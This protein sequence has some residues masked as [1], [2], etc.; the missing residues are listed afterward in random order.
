LNPDENSD[1]PRLIIGESSGGTP[2]RLIA[3]GTAAQNIIF[4]SNAAIPQPGD[5]K[6]IV[7]R[8]TASDSIIEHA[9]IEYG[10]AQGGIDISGSNPTIRNCTI[11]RNLNAGI[12]GI[13]ISGSSSPVISCCDITENVYGIYSSASSGTLNITNN[14]IFGN[15]SHG[16]Y[17]TSG[18]N[19]INALHNWWGDA[20]G[21]GGVGPGSGDA[22]SGSVDYDPWLVAPPEQTDTDSDGHGD[23]CDNCPET[24]N[25]DQ[26]DTNRDGIGD[27]CEQV[28]RWKGD[29]N[30]DRIV[31]ISDVILVL[32]MALDLDDDV[33]CADINDDTPVD[34]SDVILTLRMVLGL[35]EFQPC[36]G[37]V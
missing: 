36:T 11:R 33:P 12:A 3:Q 32:R 13:T 18:S 10:G 19:I 28:S 5:W 9:I 26:E 29:I 27:A 17:N 6:E 8:S 20:S 15:S 16:I 37:E 22:V 14:N 7:L 21:P 4:T 25:P 2:G 35:D 24:P 1:N 30:E 23:A 34:I 31:D